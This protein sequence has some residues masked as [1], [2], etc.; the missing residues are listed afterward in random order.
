MLFR[1]LPNR[2]P[3]CDDVFH[4][5]AVR[6]PRRDAL[7]EHLLAAGVKTEV[8]YPVPPFRQK[9]LQGRLKGE[10]FPLADLIH[11]TEISL[12]ISIFHEPGEIS[13]VCRTL[14]GFRG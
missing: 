3:A 6:H 5:F 9:A 12:P 13:Q 14:N 4:I 10:V 7:R 2:D 8:H 1:S 11:A